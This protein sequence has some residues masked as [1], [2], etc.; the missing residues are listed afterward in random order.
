MD[1]STLKVTELK[2][3]L[4]KREIPA[5]KL[6]RKQEII[7]RLLED[8]AQKAQP[9]SDEPIATHTDGR[10]TSEPPINAAEAPAEEKVGTLKRDATPVIAELP[11]V[12]S[13]Q[14]KLG[15]FEDAEPST[16]VSGQPDQGINIA[17]LPAA[18]APVNANDA[19][20]EIAAEIVTTTEQPAEPTAEPAS[21]AQ[22][23]DNVKADAAMLDAPDDGRKRKERSETAPE[24]NMPHVKKIKQDSPVPADAVTQPDVDMQDAVD[25]KRAVTSERTRQEEVNVE[26]ALHPAT[27]ALYI[28]GLV[29]PVNQ[30]ALKDHLCNLSRSVDPQQAVTQLHIDTLRSHAL[31]ILDSTESAVNIRASLHTKVWP[32]EPARKSLWVDF[33]PEDKCKE[34]VTQENDAGNSSRSEIRRWEVRYEKSDSG[35]QVNLVDAASGSAPTQTSNHKSARSI[36]HSRRD[37]HA[38]QSPVPMT[39]E[40]TTFRKLDECF[41]FTTCKPKLYWLPVDAELA[42]QRRQELASKTSREWSAKKDFRLNGAGTGN[43][44]DQLRRVTFE[45]GAVLVDGGIEHPRRR[46]PPVSDRGRGRG[47]PR[48]YGGGDRY[49]DRGG[50][51]W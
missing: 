47:P 14:G 39:T 12:P 7:D 38:A 4:K 42:R 32:D 37:D 34:F 2:Q 40:N 51:R 50:R 15:N 28:A 18:P 13:E 45:D 11:S 20:H 1:Y 41:K 24:T 26:P 23:I 8:D 35:V 48:G 5:T 22:P 3:E 46:G 6:T 44:L 43:G 9:I 31:V 16:V 10:E 49:P 36:S 27:N 30:N 19:Q 29:R 25:D 17:P 33:L 21:T